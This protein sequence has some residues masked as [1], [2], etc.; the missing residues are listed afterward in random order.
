MRRISRDFRDKDA[1][2]DVLSFVGDLATAEGGDEHSSAEEPMAEPSFGGFEPEGGPYLGDIVISVPTARRQAEIRGHSV[3][4][5]LRTLLLHGLLHCL[6][7][8]H[9]TD[10]GTMER[11]EDQLRTHYGIQ[12]EGIQTEG[13][14]TEGIDTDRIDT[15][16]I[17]TE[18]VH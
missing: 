2:T 10:D 11:F 13:I 15:E 7:Y 18:V 9:E 1:T 16:G 12:T 14:D 5:E 4:R 8:D 6:G 3:E 17:E